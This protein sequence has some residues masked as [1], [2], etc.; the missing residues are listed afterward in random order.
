MREGLERITFYVDLYSRVDEESLRESENDHESTDGHNRVEN[1][2]RNKLENLYCEILNFLA[3]AVRYFHRNTLLKSGSN[4]LKVDDWSKLTTKVDSLKDDCKSLM[5]EFNSQKQQEGMKRIEDMIQKQAD[6][7]EN[8]EILKWLSSDDA[9][10]EHDEV[11]RKLQDKLGKGFE[12]SGEGLRNE[13]DRWIQS[14]EKAT[15]WLC[16]SG[17]WFNFFTMK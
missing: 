4:L 14:S 8:K 11:R 15:L 2:L 3:R 10:A 9:Q 16:G 13:Y 1:L 7:Q 6:Q 12:S 5:D 17:T